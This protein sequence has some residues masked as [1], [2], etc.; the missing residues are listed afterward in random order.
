MGTMLRPCD[1]CLQFCLVLLLIV[2]P[3]INPH[4]LAFATVNFTLQ[5]R[6]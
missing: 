1:L 2:Q 3:H 5:E 6:G 4:R